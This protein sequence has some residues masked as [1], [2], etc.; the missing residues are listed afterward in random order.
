MNF[1]IFIFQTGTYAN[2]LVSRV[3]HVQDWGPPAGPRRLA[4]VSRGATK[5]PISA[6]RF[7]TQSSL[8]PLDH[9]HV[10]FLRQPIH[11]GADYLQ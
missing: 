11:S 1:F 7:P 2:G 8:E 4:H 10:W 9:A 3:V 5:P 6:V